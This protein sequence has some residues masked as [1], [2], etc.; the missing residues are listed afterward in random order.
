MER[1]GSIVKRE[2]G[3]GGFLQ[4]TLS[5]FQLQVVEFLD[6]GSV[7]PGVSYQGGVAQSFGNARAPAVMH[8]NLVCTLKSI[9]SSEFES[10]RP[11]SSSTT[12]A[13]TQSS[14]DMAEVLQGSEQSLPRCAHTK[15]SIVNSP[16]L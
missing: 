9:L 14:A 2:A 11:S 10:C 5:R 13:D 15:V 4:S 3:G 6:Q 16:P 7:V 1:A 12:S 8:P